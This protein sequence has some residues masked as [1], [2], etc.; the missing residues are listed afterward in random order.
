M[1]DPLFWLGLSIFLLAVSLTVVLVVALPALQELS[2]AARSAE[3]LFDTLNRELPP[4]LEAIRLTGMEMSELTDDMSEGV[5]SA[6][7][8]VKQVEQG[9]SSTRRQAQKVQTATRS[10]WVGAKAAWKTFTR[11]PSSRRRSRER[12]LPVSSRPPIDL[13]DRQNHPHTTR[14]P[15]KGWED[16]PHKSLG[17]RLI[18]PAERLN[19]YEMNG[20]AAADKD[21]I[22]AN[23]LESTSQPEKLGAIDDG[24]SAPESSET[25]P[26]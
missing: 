12:H 19:A 16:S 15:P 8:L 21:E 26:R 11:R 13:E 17:E 9:L 25:A 3:K 24:G 6:G 18:Q 2:R 1:A 7:Q 22:G 23:P 20:Q 5:Q 4:T 10:V 14:R